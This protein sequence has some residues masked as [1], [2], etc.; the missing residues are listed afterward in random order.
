MPDANSPLPAAGWYPDPDNAAG[1]R[2]W[3]GS[4]W[5]EERRAREAAPTAVAAA[6][7]Y[8]YAPAGATAP[9]PYGSAPAAP[10]YG[11][12]TAYGAATPQN[13][14]GLVGFIISMASI[15]VG[16]YG[17]TGIAGG[18]I[19]IIGYTKAL[20]LQRAG[21]VQHRKGMALAG[22]IVGFGSAVLTWV[23]LGLIFATFSSP[24]YGY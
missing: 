2:W 22:I 13:V 24:N 21:V 5:G 17:L 9:S 18:V 23:V 8:A 10:P 12:Y 16:I 19:S 7:T 20:E 15:V 11:S 3:N 14:I 4:A 6:P 1:D